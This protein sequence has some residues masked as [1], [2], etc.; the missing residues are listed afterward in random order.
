MSISQLTESLSQQYPILS[1]TYFGNP[2][3]GYILAASSLPVFLIS[4]KLIQQVLIKR[5]E[6]WARTT[7]TQ[8]DDV[9]I[10]IIKSVK[11]PFYTYFALYL[12]LRLLDLGPF[13]TQASSITLITW[14]V[15]QAIS[16]AQIF[17]DYLAGTY[18]GPQ[19]TES[20]Q[21]DTAIQAIKLITKLLLWSLGLLLILSNMGV[22]ITSLIAGL[23]IGGVAVALAVQN[24]LGDLFSSLALYFDK[25]FKVGD[26]II[27]GPQMG[28]VQKIGIK[29]TRLRALQGEELIIPNQQLTSEVIQNFKRMKKRR[30]TF[31]FGLTY[32]T[33]L[34]KL[35][36]AA[37]TVQDIIKKQRKAEFDRAHFHNFGDSSLNFEVVY[38][39]KSGDYNQYMDTQ[40]TINLEIL[41]RF[42]KLGIDMAFP[43]RTVYLHNHP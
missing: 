6:V 25:P 40:Q 33:S 9:A 8:F 13:V 41:G 7:S 39:I 4:F 17:I 5:L 27:V 3:S 15:Y 2:L 29:T 14:S 32:D 43:T 30:V 36:Q 16:A 31:T 11:P 21:T 42:N 19:T 20:S 1:Q 38:Y 12:S 37:N 18:L 24:I 35:R 26:F 34:A 28:T 10:K 23:G 22:D